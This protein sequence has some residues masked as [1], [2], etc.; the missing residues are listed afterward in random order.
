MTIIS[1]ADALALLQ[2]RGATESLMRHALAAEAVMR[3]LA[4]KLGHDAEL[5]GRTGLLHDL[6]YP[7]TETEPARHGLMTAELLAEHL[8]CEALQ[9]IRAH[10]GGMNGQAPATVFDYALRCGETVTGLI[11]A[12]A[13]MRPT[14]YEGMAVKSI[15][16]KMKDKAFAASVS[17]DNIRECE[18][19]GVPLDDFLALAIDA[20]AR[21]DAAANHQ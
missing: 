6:D 1:R 20:M 18:Q 5:W 4:E 2:S 11:S 13:L 14:R 7:E 10:N 17:R 15:K 21:Q 19:A 12:A 3:A 16:K 9:A 8:P